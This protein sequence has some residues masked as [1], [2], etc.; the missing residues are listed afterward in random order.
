ML[1][2][3]QAEHELTVGEKL[4][5]GN[6]A[7]HSRVAAACAR[8]IACRC[9]LD[10]DKS[11]IFGLLHDIGRRSGSWDSRHVFDGYDYMMTGPFAP[12]PEIARICLTHSYPVKDIRN[13]AHLIKCTDAQRD[14]LL[15]F[16][17]HTEY[18]DYDKLI[19]LCDAVSLPTGACIVEKRLIDV[20]LRHG[21]HQGTVNKHRAFLVL[22]EYF[23]KLCGCNI[24][25]FLPNVFENSIANLPLV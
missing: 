9:A 12:Q 4:T 25:S 22:K 20:E 5:P 16:L 8:M 11:Y 14:F 15:D 19:Q 2:I 10:A 1:T 18:D 23:D 13:Y 21:V 17:D 6:W 3:E 7:L 24:Y